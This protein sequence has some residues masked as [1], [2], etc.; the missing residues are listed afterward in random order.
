MR[1][2][3]IFIFTNKSQIEFSNYILA[4]HQLVELLGRNTDFIRGSGVACDVV[5]AHAVEI[6][7]PRNGRGVG[8]FGFIRK[9][10]T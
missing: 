7:C 9:V 1:W 6:R 10:Y 2:N 4:R 3:L 8:I 5:G